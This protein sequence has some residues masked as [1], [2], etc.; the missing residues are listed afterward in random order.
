[1]FAG[2]PQG[3][4]ELHRLGGFLLPQW[5]NSRLGHYGHGFGEFVRIFEEAAPKDEY[6]VRAGAVGEI[7][8][9]DLVRVVRRYDQVL[10]PLSPSRPGRP[11]SPL[12]LRPSISPTEGI[13]R[14]QKSS[15]IPHKP[16]GTSIDYRPILLQ[17]EIA[18]RIDDIGVRRRDQCL[19]IEPLLPVRQDVITLAK[20]LL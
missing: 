19:G 6:A 2:A 14:C 15:R 5:V 3:V 11:T 16:G 1:M 10:P 4:G 7:T 20:D 8:R 13:G 17:V 12:H 9:W 18:H